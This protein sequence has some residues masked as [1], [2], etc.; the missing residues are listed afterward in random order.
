MRATEIIFTEHGLIIEIESR[1]TIYGNVIVPSEIEHN[2][3]LAKTLPLLVVKAEYDLHPV[4]S[5]VAYRDRK[6][7]SYEFSPKRY[8]AS[9]YGIDEYVWEGGHHDPMWR[10]L[11]RSNKYC[12]ILEEASSRWFDNAGFLLETNED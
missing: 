3:P 6:R 1:C 7:S 2:H 8:S 4:S 12:E 10:A 5:S 11:G 9:F